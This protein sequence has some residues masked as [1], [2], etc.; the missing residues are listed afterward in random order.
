M[1]ISSKN[2]IQGAPMIQFN[3]LYEV[4]DVIND[5]EIFGE[6]FDDNNFSFKLVNLA[7]NATIK[8]LARE[9]YYSKRVKYLCEIN[10][11]EG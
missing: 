11:F 1:A 7:K 9:G 8:H 2:Q 4:G 3:L 10:D 5:G 6:V